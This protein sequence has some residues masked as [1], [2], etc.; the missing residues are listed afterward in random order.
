M[1]TAMPKRGERSVTAQ[2]GHPL[3][4]RCP[5]FR[6]TMAGRASLLLRRQGPQAMCWRV[7]LWQP[8]ECTRALAPQRP[9][10]FARTDLLGRA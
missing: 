4:E 3:R 2:K 1:N 9:S 7:A 8:A 5:S 10:W 6:A